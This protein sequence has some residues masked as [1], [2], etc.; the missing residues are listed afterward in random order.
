MPE[1]SRSRPAR[2]PLP[3]QLPPPPPRSAPL[4]PGPALALGSRRRRRRLP[5]PGPPARPPPPPARA[6]PLGARPPAPIEPRARPLMSSP[7]RRR[8]PGGFK[9]P[10]PS[11]PEDAVLNDSCWD[12]TPNLKAQGCGQLELLPVPLLA[13]PLTH[14]EDALSLEQQLSVES[15][16]T[17]VPPRRRAALHWPLEQWAG[18]LEDSSGTGSPHDDIAEEIRVHANGNLPVCLTPPLNGPPCSSG[19]QEPTHPLR[20]HPGASGD[21]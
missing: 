21:H 16:L 10:A 3:A 2:Q 15:Q 14:P 8:R 5:P 1:D 9:G 12:L 6:L 19:H 17:W 7:A 18:D 11:A 13:H 4:G 20:K